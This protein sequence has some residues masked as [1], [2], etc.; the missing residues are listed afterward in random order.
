M[1][2][3]RPLFKLCFFACF[4]FVLTMHTALADGFLSGTEDV[5]L[6][7]GIVLSDEETFSFDTE[8]GRI[9]ISKG[10]SK[11]D[12]TKVLSFYR[13]TLPQLGW[14]EK[15][16]GEFVRESDILRIAVTDDDF[17]GQKSTSA[18]FELITKS[19]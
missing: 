17:D 11:N 12:S 5:P 4:S 16:A 13:Q 18:I 6:M 10:I 8:N 2:L 15:S 7:D 14:Q 3:C 1:H 19:K 9:Y